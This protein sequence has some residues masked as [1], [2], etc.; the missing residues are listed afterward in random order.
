MENEKEKQEI[1]ITTAVDITCRTTDKHREAPCIEVKSPKKIQL[2][3]HQSE[4]L[5]TWEDAKHVILIA[6]TGSGKTTTSLVYSQELLKLKQDLRC[7]FVIPQII[8]SPGYKSSIVGT[9]LNCNDFCHGENRLSRL[10]TFLTKIKGGGLPNRRRAICS[11]NLIVAA[12]KRIKDKSLFDDLLLWID[13]A[14]HI[15]SDEDLKNG[16]GEVVTATLQRQNSYIGMSTATFFRFDTL[17]IVPE[18]HLKSFSKYELPYDIYLKRMQHIER[19]RISFVYYRDSYRKA[20]IGLLKEKHKT[21]VYLPQVN[22]R[23]SSGNKIEDV[24]DILTKLGAGNPDCNGVQKLPDGRK[25]LN[26]VEESGQKIRKAYLN[27]RIRDKLLLNSEKDYVDIILCVGM[28]KEGFD[29]VFAERILQVGVKSSIGA[30]LQVNGRLLRDM[31]KVADVLMLLP[32]STSVVDL[33]H[34][35]KLNDYLKAVYL[36]MLL[37]DVYDPIPMPETYSHKGFRESSTYNPL[38]QFLAENKEYTIEM[39]GAEAHCII[40][41]LADKTDLKQ[42]VKEMTAFLGNDSLAEDAAKKICNM[43]C[44]CQ[45]REQ[46]LK[47]RFSDVNISTNIDLNEGL[48]QRFS[49]VGLNSTFFNNVRKTISKQ[50]KYSYEQFLAI[51][52]KYKVV[53]YQQYS[54]IIKNFS[55]L[56]NNPIKAYPNKFWG[57][58]N[59]NGVHSDAISKNDVNM[60][61]F[62]RYWDDQKQRRQNGLEDL[63]MEQFTEVING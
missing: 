44:R 22:W 60:D 27:K 6:P 34:E 11:H 23:I 32:D 28:A 56:P 63:T 40:D 10:I 35:E 17:Q 20:I 39:I 18:K 31:P 29:W 36:A 62:A 38:A 50:K 45:I 12:W 55:R 26:L 61:L 9:M 4:A 16:L 37:E 41:D 21:I 58:A 47:V 49:N 51:I 7:L 48:R 3:D 8:I 24:N 2:R 43:I 33:R 30:Q 53:R 5:K 1:R 59:A 42:F 52:K 13:E 54:I 14:H 19:I 15:A 46:D 57:F 25:I